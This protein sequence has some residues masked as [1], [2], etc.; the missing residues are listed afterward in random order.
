[1]STLEGTICDSF[2]E[3]ERVRKER[4][5]SLVGIYRVRDRV[6]EERSGSVRSG[7]ERM[8]SSFLESGGNVMYR[9]DESL[10]DGLEMRYNL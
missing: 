5:A 10:G 4:K 9:N 1:M 3:N 6:R 2:R 8:P 7:R